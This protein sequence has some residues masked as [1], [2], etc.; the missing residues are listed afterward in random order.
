MELLFSNMSAQW[1]IIPLHSLIHTLCNSF[2]LFHI[3]TYPHVQEVLHTSIK[4][5]CR[6]EEICMS[7]WETRNLSS[8]R[9]VVYLFIDFVCLSRFLELLKL[10]YLSDLSL[11]AELNNYKHSQTDIENNILIIFLSV[12]AL[13]YHPSL[14]VGGRCREAVLRVSGWNYW[15]TGFI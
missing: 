2:W 8:P 5:Q 10:L 4:R 12:Q 1:V 15:D 9:S 3:R 13:V 7:F 11:Y 14:S 6:R